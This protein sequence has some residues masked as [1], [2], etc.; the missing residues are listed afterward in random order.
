MRLHLENPSEDE[1]LA[2]SNFLTGGNHTELLRPLRVR[3]LIR[4]SVV[5]RE[6]IVVSMHLCDE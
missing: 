3:A 4:L 2:S 6:A 5:K 1:I